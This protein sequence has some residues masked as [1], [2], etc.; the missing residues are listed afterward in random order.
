MAGSIIWLILYGMSIGQRRKVVWLFLLLGVVAH[1]LIDGWRWQMIPAYVGIGLLSLMQWAK[2]AP[3]VWRILLSVLLV[4]LLLIGGLLSVLLPVYKLP[5]P[6]GSYQV[7]VQQYQL[8]DLDREDEITADQDDHRRIAVK[9][10]YPSNAR[11]KDRLTNYP[12]DY[13]AAF[14]ANQGMPGFI[15][16]H[17]QRVR[18]HSGWDLPMADI[19]RAPVLIWSHGLMWNSTLYLSMIEELVSKGF[20]IVAPDH[21]Y[22]C[23]L[24]IIDNQPVPSAR[25]YFEEMA[26]ANWDRVH[27]LQDSILATDDPDLQ[28]DLTKTIQRELPYQE[29]LDRWTRDL[30]VVV[31]DIIQKTESNHPVFSNVDATQL[32]LCGHSWGGAAAV[33]A[34]VHD[35]RFK[36][37]SNLDGAV[38]ADVMSDSLAIPMMTLYAER[39]YDSFFTPNFIVNEV[40]AR[41]ANIELQIAGADHASFGDLNY[42]SP[43][44][45][46]TQTGTISPQR[47]TKMVAELLQSFYIDAVAGSSD[48]LDEMIGSGLYPEITILE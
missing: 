17:F 26:D 3:R 29:S 9:V 18:T 46:L 30:I 31:D 24:T 28:R 43:I 21:T 4:L 10:W 32:G 36:S 20:V 22:E 6:T 41:N 7:G 35:G 42:W 33:N 38:W 39:D 23:P 8:E 15:G 44:R 1:L 13:A 34:A 14:L 40:I 27:R 16:S 11:L 37:V 2:I 5:V 48:E 45:G 47:M 12:P 25:Q 19:D